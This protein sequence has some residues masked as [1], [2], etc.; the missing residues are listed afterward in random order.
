MS[1]DSSYEGMSEPECIVSE[2][3]RDELKIWWHYEFPIFVFDE[4]ERPRVWIPDFFLPNLGIYIEVVGSR[5]DWEDNKQN[6]QNRQ[7][8]F[9]KNK[10]NV[11]FIHFWR[12]DWRSHTIRMIQRIEDARY[13]E[14][15]NLFRKK[16]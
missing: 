13:N 2:Y 10:F 9:K 5:K 7:K 12:K 11:I 4:K 3:L 14:V 16:N 6:Y 1:K 15:K 8:I